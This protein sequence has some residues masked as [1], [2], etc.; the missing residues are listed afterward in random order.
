MS[1]PL[2]P[3]WESYFQDTVARINAEWQ[4]YLI[5]ACGEGFAVSVAGGV[6]TCKITA[7]QAD[8]L[9]HRWNQ[10][11]FERKRAVGKRRT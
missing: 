10:A 2:P 11:A 5:D 1:L 9:K 3:D 4:P 7:E 6:I 8:E